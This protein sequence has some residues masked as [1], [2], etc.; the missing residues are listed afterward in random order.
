MNVAFD[1]SGQSVLV[2]G[3]SR[4]IG[5]GVAEAFAAAGARLSI[6]AEDAGVHQAAAAIQ[7]ATGQPV[8]AIECDISDAAA[9]AAAVDGFDRI[10]VLVNN[11]GIERPTPVKGQHTAVDTTFERIMAVNVV[12]SWQ[13]TRAA[14]AKMSRGGRILMTSSIWGHT[15][16]PEF[17]GYVSSKHALVGM[18]R[19]LSRELGGRGIRVNAVCPGWVRTESALRSLATMANEQGVA[20]ATLQAEIVAGQSLDGLMGPEDVAGLYLYLA[21]DAAANITGQAM[22]IDRGEVMR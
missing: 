9:V 22:I 1:F 8:T 17:A 12:G 3:A 21:S 4:G 15:A 7:A 20:P 13:M 18:V 10:D 6:L 2:T 19:S 14:L 11:A 16:V 5:Y